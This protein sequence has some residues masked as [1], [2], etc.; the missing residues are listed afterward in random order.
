MKEAIRYKCIQSHPN[1]NLIPW[2]HKSQIVFKIPLVLGHSKGGK[3]KPPLYPPISHTWFENRNQWQ[4]FGFIAL[5]SLEE[6]GTF[7]FAFVNLRSSILID[8]ICTLIGTH[9]VCVFMI[10]HPIKPFGRHLKFCH[11]CAL[12]WMGWICKQEHFLRECQSW[13]FLLPKGRSFLHHCHI[14]I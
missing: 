5:S 3:I 11:W 9:L 4:R 10:A 6:I 12:D 2:S 13:M 1:S 8:Q 7:W 14:T